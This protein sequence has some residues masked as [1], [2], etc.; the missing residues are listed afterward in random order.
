MRCNITSVCQYNKPRSLSFYHVVKFRTNLA[1][2][3]AR[4]FN[5]NVSACPGPSRRHNTT[6]AVASLVPPYLWQRSMQTA[7]LGPGQQIL[8]VLLLATLLHGVGQV[9]TSVIARVVTYMTR[10]AYVCLP[11]LKTDGH[12]HAYIHSPAS[13]SLSLSLTHTHTHTHT[14]DTHSHTHT[15]IHTLHCHTHT[16]PSTNALV[17]SVLPMTATGR[18]LLIHL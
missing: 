7:G 8:A 10:A 18:Q 6:Y 3:K 13:L 11:S 1:L 4:M 17:Q 15:H 14:H 5:R 9:S 2:S 12:T 16:A